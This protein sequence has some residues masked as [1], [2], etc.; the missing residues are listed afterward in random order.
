M[1]QSYSHINIFF[2]IIKYIDMDSDSFSSTVTE[3]IGLCIMRNWLLNQ[4]FTVF[5]FFFLL[6]DGL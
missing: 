6:F 1:E 3:L 5:L 2:I 4:N